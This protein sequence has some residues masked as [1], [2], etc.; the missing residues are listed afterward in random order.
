MIDA[1]Q[2]ATPTLTIM[3]ACIDALQPPNWSYTTTEENV[4]VL[5]IA[6]VPILAG[7]HANAGNVG[8]PVA[9][10]VSLHEELERLIQADLSTLDVLKAVTKGPAHAFGLLDRGVIKPGYRAHLVLI[11]GDPLGHILNSRKIERVW[12]GGIEYR[13][14]GSCGRG[15]I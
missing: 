14:I 3:R 12:A 4:Q 1:N 8:A 7:T 10:G 13:D 2:I 11:G 9:F 5:K 15:A 6:G